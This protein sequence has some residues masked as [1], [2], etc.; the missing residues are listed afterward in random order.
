M[1]HSKTG[2]PCLTSK[3]SL[4]RNLIILIFD[5]KNVKMIKIN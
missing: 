5:A 2:L 3:L 1:V 4:I